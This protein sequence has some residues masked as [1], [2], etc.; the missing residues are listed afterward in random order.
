M[1][2]ELESENL[3]I[4]VLFISFEHIKQLDNALKRKMYQRKIGREIYISFL[5]RKQELNQQP[6]VNISFYK[7]NLEIRA[8]Y[9]GCKLV[10]IIFIDYGTE[11]RKA[12]L[13]MAKSGLHIANYIPK[14]LSIDDTN[15]SEDLRLKITQNRTE[16]QNHEYRLKIRF[17]TGHE[18]VQVTSHED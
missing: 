2:S 5:K 1:I 3:A 7:R 6:N 16:W 17:F 8:A 9:H 15:H 10:P 14:S 11:S 18:N 4:K 12:K 13:R